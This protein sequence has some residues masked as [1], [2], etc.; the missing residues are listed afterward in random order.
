MNEN[1]QYLDGLDP[2]ANFFNNYFKSVD[3]QYQS[4]YFTV[5][6]FNE[7]CENSDKNFSICNYNIRSFNANNEEFSALLNSLSIDFDVIILTETR[8]RA[9]VGLNMS[10]YNGHHSS[11]I[12]G[13]GGGVSVYCRSNLLVIGYPRLTL[14]EEYIEVCTVEVMINK[15]KI[16]IIAIYRPPNGSI[17]RFIETLQS[18]VNDPGIHDSELVLT[19]DFNLNLIDYENSNQRTNDFVYVLF[20]LNFMPLITKPTRFPIGN[21]RGSPA[22]LDHIWCNRYY[23][24]VSGIITY[25]SSDH[26]PTF[27]FINNLPVREGELVKI[28]FR[29]FSDNHM[30]M[31]LNR[32]AEFRMY[33][34][35]DVNWDVEHFQHAI[36]EIYRRCFP[37]K[38]KYVSNKR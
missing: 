14:I 27:L 23:N 1:V 28:V 21:Q 20:S 10:G 29:D 3:V 8:F 32:C 25:E 7:L 5:D 13:G 16:V 19:G 37:I 17:E 11:R 6:S 30:S 18:I 22:L 36:N 9:D 33:F 26:L 34:S 12:V 31:F 35:G 38:T 4:N 24:Y 15:R 2:E